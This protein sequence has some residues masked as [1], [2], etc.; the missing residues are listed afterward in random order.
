MLKHAKNHTKINAALLADYT[1]ETFM[2]QA[3]EA[4]RDHEF[5]ILSDDEN[6]LASLASME[7]LPPHQFIGIQG[8]VHTQELLRVFAPYVERGRK[9]LLLVD[10]SRNLNAIDDDLVIEKWTNAASE[11]AKLL[12]SGLV[13]L[14]NQDLLI[15]GQMQPVLQAH[16]SFLAPSGIYQNPFYL[17]PELQ[18]ASVDQHLAH[19]LTRIVPDY[20]G[21]AFFDN[22]GRSIARGYEAGA[23]SSAPKV[24][25]A[26]PQKSCWHVRCF[27]PLNVY[28]DGAK[29]DWQLK[30]SAPHKTRTLF[31]YM[32]MAGERGVHVEQISE[33]LWPD[34]E[35]EETKRGRLHH[36]I[37]MLR[38]TLCDKQSVL[39][40]GEYYQ[41]NIPKDCWTDVST[42]EQACRRG[43]YLAKE[44]KET[45]ALKLYQAAENLYLGD[46]FQGLPIKY[47]HSDDVDWCLPRRRWLREMAIKLL[48]DS[49]VC[50]RSMDRAKEALEKCQ[51]AL[52]LDPMNENVNAELMR[53][54][55]MQGRYDAIE[56]QYQQ[57]LENSKVNDK[58]DEI[59][60]IYKN[61]M[62]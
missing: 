15:E 58:N 4:F 35:S 43:L 28:I 50:L 27:G 26:K 60:R 57:Y 42:F 41:L 40:S 23:L 53:V 29:V 12:P 55:H 48:R 46:L 17:P 2:L 1:D 18:S 61:L 13:S 51:K 59:T 39:R 7:R 30:G 16:P 36:A 19:F 14:Y 49:S 37:A 56:R 22:D 3:L 45:E 62:R 44:G 8:R 25:L 21:I 20:E 32:L 54:Y 9:V 5:V 47:T 38:K 11:L 31:A 24:E 34:G 10:L 52:Q 33:L 6:V